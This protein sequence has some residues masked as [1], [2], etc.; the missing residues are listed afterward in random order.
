MIQFQN[1]TKMYRTT[2]HPNIILDDVTETIPTDRNVAIMGRNG[3]GKSTLLRL[4]AK[5]ERPT[6]GRIM[7]RGR[8]SWPMSFAGGI[9]TH[10]SAIDNIRFVSRIYGQ[11]WRRVVDFVEDMAELG[12]Y[13]HMPIGTFSSGMRARTNLALSLAINFDVYLVDEIP[14]VNDARFKKKYDDA[15]AQAR[16]NAAFVMVSHN[17][18]TIRE[19]CDLVFV[20]N[21]G[22]LVRFDSVEEGLEVYKNL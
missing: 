12:T 18:Q 21:K 17:L 19:S 16:S 20:L 13:L 9:H 7:S 10:L 4:V 15:I 3:A 5:S 22:K 1:V 14:T 8:I 6:G 11:N 2:G